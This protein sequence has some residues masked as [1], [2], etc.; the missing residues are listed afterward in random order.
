M[1]QVFETEL[2]ELWNDTQ[3]RIVI[4][5]L[6]QEIKERYAHKMVDYP[7]WWQRRFF[8]WKTKVIRFSLDA[9]DVIR[10]IAEGT[11]PIREMMEY[12]AEK[13]ILEFSLSDALRNNCSIVINPRKTSCL[14]KVRTDGF[15]SQ[16][17]EKELVEVEISVMIYGGL[18]QRGLYNRS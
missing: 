4:P 3:Q 1:K 14:F 13:V 10:A 17:W 8:N 15:G 11:D 2:W 7:S 9:Q 5:A 18:K 6:I 16:L 12:V